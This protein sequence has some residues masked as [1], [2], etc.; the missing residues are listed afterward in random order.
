MKKEETTVNA[1]TGLVIKQNRSMN[2]SR[3]LNCMVLI[4]FMVNY[5]LRVN[6][7]IA[8][9]DMVPNNKQNFSREQ[10][11]N[12][13][14]S[15]LN[16]TIA[17]TSKTYSNSSNGM[18]F[19]WSEYEQNFI[20]GSFYWGY[21]LTELPGGRLAEMIGARPVFGYSMLLASM[22]TLLTPMAAKMGFYFIIICRVI[23]GFT[24]G[25]TWPAI[26]PLAANW[27]PPNERSKFMANMMASTLGAAFTLPICGILISAWGW[28]SVFYITGLIGIAWSVMW[29]NLIFETP[30][31]HPRISEYERNYIETQIAK[32]SSPGTKPHKLPWKNIL[33]SLPVWAIVITHGASVFGYFT[34]VNQLPTYMK[35]LL[36]YDIKA[37]GLLSSLPYLG[38][39]FMAFTAGII[40]DRILNAEKMTKT[41]TRK[42]F[43]A[44]GV[45]APGLLMILQAYFGENAVWSVVIFTIALTLNGAVTGGYLGNGL[46]IAPNFSGTIFGMANTLSSFGGFL[47]SYIVGKLTNNNQTFEQWR[48]VFW[49]LA[50]TYMC[51]ALIFLI[52]GT[53]KTLSWNSE[54]NKAELNGLQLN[55]PEL[56][57]PLQN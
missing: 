46:D 53:A 4:G 48:I 40:A 47:S 30:A 16:D 19:I 54:S 21:V 18:K 44:I 15:S 17:T 26:L 10:V 12:I 37:N 6:F 25:V 1:E 39:F 50:I 45:F 32:Q 11:N 31:E 3:V 52:F 2:C 51:G 29:F 27:I 42:I 55:E 7:T 23:L 28:E 49:I 9:V 41:M 5:M 13:S 20:L 43:T 38:K 33:T 36:H 8:I 34:I 57:K 56:T 24:L 35:Y 22:V 14:S